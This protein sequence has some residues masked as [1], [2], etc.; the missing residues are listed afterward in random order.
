[1]LIFSL[2]KVAKLLHSSVKAVKSSEGGLEVCCLMILKSSLGRFLALFSASQKKEFFLFLMCFLYSLRS[3]LRRSRWIIDGLFLQSLSAALSCLLSKLRSVLNQD[4]EG[5]VLVFFHFR[6]AIWSRMEVIVALYFSVSLA[7]ED[8]HVVM[9]RRELILSSRSV[10]LICLR[11]LTQLKES[12]VR[13]GR[14]QV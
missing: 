11:F 5:M 9:G 13:G 12:C 1:M 10:W 14:W 8:S 3:D 7:V 4:L 6:G 2:K